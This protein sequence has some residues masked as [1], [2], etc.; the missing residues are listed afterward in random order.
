MTDETLN[1]ITFEVLRH[2]LVGVVD[3]MADVLELAGFS[4]IVNQGRD[5]SA[6]ICDA[7]GGLVAE[8]ERDLPGHVGT[9]PFSTRGTLAWIGRE[10]LHEGDVIIMNDPFIGGTHT[11]DVRCLMPV[12]WEGELICFVTNSVH[13]SDVGGPIPGSF[14]SGAD[15]VLQEG[16]S[17]TP[18]HLVREGELNQEVFRLIL[19][20]VRV[21]E[22]TQGDIMAQIE[23]CRTGQMRLHALCEKYG[24]ELILAEMRALTDYA[25]TLIREQFR[26]IPDGTYSWTDYIDR[27][28]GA[29]EEKPIKIELRMTIV[30]DAATFDLSDSDRHARGAVNAPSS[31]TMSAILVA[32][33]AVFP[34]IPAN[35]GMN[36]ALAVLIEPGTIVG[37]QY[38]APVS[39]AFATVFDKVASCVYGCFSQVVPERVMAAP[40]AV[41]NFN[42]GVQVQDDEGLREYIIYLWTEGGYGGRPG[43]KDNHSVITLYGSGSK[44]VPL[45]IHERLSPIRFESYEFITDSEGAGTHRGGF[46]IVKSFV[47]T[48]GEG[49]VSMIGDRGDRGPWGLDGGERGGVSGL[50]YGRGTPDEL[51]IGVFSQDV[52]IQQGPVVELWEGGGGGWGDPLTRPLEWVLDDVMDGLVSVEKAR[53][54]YGVVIEVV[55]EERLDYRVDT[56]ATEER[57]EAL[58]AT[59]G[60]NDA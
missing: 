17:I 31:L 34:H 1:P 60:A 27:D 50:M 19:R 57:R 29:A 23:A 13:W 16:L 38:P 42:L 4:L 48:E 59:R 5:L 41:G 18:I 33:R 43:K 39:G 26:E 56:G 44:N 46:G 40:N 54:A 20:N 37:A 28:P 58:A 32:T 11:M 22:L 7:D 53:D 25:E 6:S 55:D 10:N 3:E 30:G 45:E 49:V 47:L 21:P 36:R 2:A 12:F 9:I 52:G 8:G 24:K 51:D 35:E 14:N 15:S